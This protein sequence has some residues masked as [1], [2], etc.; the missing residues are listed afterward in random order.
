MWTGPTNGN[1]E[2]VRIEKRI[3][4]LCKGSHGRNLCCSCAVCTAQMLGGEAASARAVDGR[5]THR[6]PSIVAAE[7]A[8]SSHC[9]ALACQDGLGVPSCGSLL[10]NGARPAGAV[11]AAAA[12]D[13]DGLAAA[14]GDINASPLDSSLTLDVLGDVT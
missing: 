11:L 5:R 6:T 9:K 3:R 10:K 2:R 1:S 14:A 8:H 13:I 12:G 7:A 4:P